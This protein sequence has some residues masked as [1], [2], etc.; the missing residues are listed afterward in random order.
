MFIFI[1]CERKAS[2]IR[3]TI[4]FQDNRDYQ[5]LWQGFLGAGHDATAFGTSLHPT[6]VAVGAAKSFALKKL[7]K[8][9]LFAARGYN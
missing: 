1:G 3:K 2:I 8:S 4:I 6:M 5:E 9:T 7:I